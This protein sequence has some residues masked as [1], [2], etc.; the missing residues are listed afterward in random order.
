MYLDNYG[1]LCGYLVSNC[2]IRKRN[3]NKKDFLVF[4]ICWNAVY[5]KEEDCRI[6]KPNYFDV[7]Y[8]GSDSIKLSKFLQKGALVRVHYSLNQDKWEDNNGN[9]K[10]KITLNA[11]RIDVLTSTKPKEREGYSR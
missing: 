5:L 11:E 3:D 7:S 6:E 9:I 4:T 8:F 1:S 2:E 10:S